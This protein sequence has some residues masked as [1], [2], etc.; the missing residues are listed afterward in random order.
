VKTI[1]T[2]NRHNNGTHRRRRDDT[3]AAL[4]KYLDEV[5]DLQ[6]GRTPRGN[7]DG[8][9]VRTLANEFLTEKTHLLNNRE[10]VP[11]TFAEYHRTCE[12]IGGETRDQVA[13]DRIMGHEPDDMATVYRERISDERLQAVAGVVVAGWCVTPAPSRLQGAGWVVAGGIAIAAAPGGRLG[14]G[15]KRQEAQRARS[16]RSS[17]GATLSHGIVVTARQAAIWYGQEP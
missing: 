5:D 9:T 3:D 13:V 12:T 6:A 7:R 10:F 15:W 2:A 4:Q 8:L 17:A 1:E 14:R 16:T 11:Q